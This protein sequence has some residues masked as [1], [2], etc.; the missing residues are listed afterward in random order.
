LKQTKRPKDKQQGSKVWGNSPERK[1]QKSANRKERRAGASPTARSEK[2]GPSKK[3]ELRKSK[4][5]KSITLGEKKTAEYLYKL[6]GKAH[7]GKTS[8]RGV[9]WKGGKKL[10]AKGGK[11]GQAGV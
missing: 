11:K 8:L 3:T 9:A 10:F 4:P 2:R 1:T 6:L 5:P 7:R